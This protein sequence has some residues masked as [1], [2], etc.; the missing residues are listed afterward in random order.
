MKMNNRNAII[1]NVHLSPGQSKWEKA[2]RLKEIKEIYN[3]MQKLGG[4]E[5]SWDPPK[6]HCS[7]ALFTKTKN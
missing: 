1:V 6:S 4:Q 7:D 5:R 2:H 3:R